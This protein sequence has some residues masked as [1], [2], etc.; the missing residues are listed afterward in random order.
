MICYE[1]MLHDG[2]SNFKIVN[3]LQLFKK[4]ADIILANRL[5][6]DLSDIEAKVF[7]RDIYGNN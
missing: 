7:T 3:D 6:E 1:P 5:D 2:L 4:S